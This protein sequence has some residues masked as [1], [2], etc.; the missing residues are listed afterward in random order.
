MH[1]RVGNGWVDCMGTAEKERSKEVPCFFAKWQ[2]RVA[3]K[4]TGESCKNSRVR[5]TGRSVLN[6][7]RGRASLA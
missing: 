2:D 4:H 5:E 7:V 3:M 6:V 1:F